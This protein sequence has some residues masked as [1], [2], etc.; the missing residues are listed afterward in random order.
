MTNKKPTAKQEIAVKKTV[1]NMCSGNPKT[2]AEILKESG[3]SDSVAHNPQSIE[4]S[5][6][7]KALIDKY[8]PN[9]L[10]TEKHKALLEKKEVIRQKN[11]DG[12][13]EIIPT[14][15]IDA[16]AVKSGLDMAYKIK[17][18]YEKDN[19][20]KKTQVNVNIEHREQVSKALDEI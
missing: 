19:I 7:W 14:G 8:L 20:Q 13:L 5:D 15:E 18:A 12:G 17:G 11:A 16:N 9:D 2:K 3:Y 4:E 10:L 1:E 6:G